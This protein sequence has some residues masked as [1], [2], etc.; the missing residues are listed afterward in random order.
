V[1]QRVLHGP[2]YR[3]QTLVS[4]DSLWP[5]ERAHT[6]SFL[7]TGSDSAS[8]WRDRREKLVCRA[9]PV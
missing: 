8:Q 1:R 6:K 9:R 4:M 3:D 7:A 5:R 2:L